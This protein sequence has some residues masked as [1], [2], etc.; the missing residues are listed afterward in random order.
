MSLFHLSLPHWPTNGGVIKVTNI[1]TFI[2]NDASRII[3]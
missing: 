3:R 2:E 1:R